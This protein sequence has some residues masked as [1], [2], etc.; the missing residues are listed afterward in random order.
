MYHHMIECPATAAQRQTLRVIG[1]RAVEG[2]LAEAAKLVRD[3]PALLEDV[4][5]GRVVLEKGIQWHTAHGKA[6]L[7]H[8]ALA[9]TRRLVGHAPAQAAAAARA[10]SRH[11]QRP[12]P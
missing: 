7:S 11:P 9:H 4:E 3:V 8:L 5:H 1:R 12:Q 10:G 2:I 6:M